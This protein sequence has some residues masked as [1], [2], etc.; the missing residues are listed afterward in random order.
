[1]TG[2]DSGGGSG[3]RLG[4]DNGSSGGRGASATGPAA[5]AGPLW[6][7]VT[8]PE[9]QAAGWV[10][11]LRARGLQAEALPLLEIARVDDPAPVRAMFSEL[12]RCAARAPLVMF[13]SPN[14]AACFFQALV[15]P[16]AGAPPAW[17][18]GVVAAGT[19]PGTVAAL[20][21]AGVP[22]AAIVAPPADAAQFDSE[23]LW[24]LL[25]GQ[26]WAG[27]PAW[28]VRGEGG[29]DW[30]A[31]T[32][33]AAGAEVAFVQS[34]ARRAPEWG[35]AERALLARALAQ[36]ETVRWLLSSSEAVAHLGALAPGA[37][38]AGAT[39]LASHPRIAES[40]RGLGFGTVV[41]IRPTVEAVE[42]VLRR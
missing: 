16:G 6:A 41:E 1:M 15:A 7:L 32:L 22:A 30:L 28:I 17:P 24:A 25:K 39:A 12:T 18:P 14:A 33:R 31:D 8:R 23:T 10:C 5:A 13:V 19:G 20:K 35:E 11:K 27:R 38:W 37:D 2:G 29:R 4:G 3:G 26:R 36:P 40:A 42:Q 9:P 21:A 34:Y